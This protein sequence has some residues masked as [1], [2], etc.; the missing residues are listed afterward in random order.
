M[1]FS[2]KIVGKIL[3]DKK[4]KNSDKDE[5]TPKPDNVTLKRW[6]EYKNKHKE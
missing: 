5:E 1:S 4:S 2:H 6:N 3:G